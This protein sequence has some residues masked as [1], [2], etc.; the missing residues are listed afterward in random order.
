MKADDCDIHLR[1]LALAAR[2][3]PPDSRDRRLALSDLVAAVWASG[4]L[5]CPQKGAW[6]PALYDDLHREALQR[7]L[8]EVCQKIDRYDPTRPVLAWVNFRLH[9]QFIDTVREFYKQGLT[10]APKGVPFAVGPL[11][12]LDTLDRALATD[13]EPDERQLL[14]QFLT[15][16]PEGRLRAEHIRNRPDAHFQAIALARS[17]EHKSWEEIAAQFGISVQTLCSFFN[18]RLQKLRPHFQKYLRA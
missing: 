10:A 8:L 3:H 16:D 6:P 1:E 15:D 11:P 4:R 2:H 14:R 7:T 18:R 5:A 13:P 12:T 9:K 17:V